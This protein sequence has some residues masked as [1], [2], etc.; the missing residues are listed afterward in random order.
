M[1]KH[2]HYLLWTGGFDSTFRLVE[3]L[4]NGH[5]VQPLYVESP[6][7]SSR[8][9][10]ENAR[11]NILKTLKNHDLKGAVLPV[12]KIDYASIPENPEITEAFKN[13]RRR[14]IIGNQYEYLARLLASRPDL[15]GTELAVEDLWSE[16]DNFSKV[17]RNLCPLKKSGDAYIINLKTS[18]KE[19]RLLFEN[20]RFGIADRTEPEMLNLLKNWGFNDIL[21][22]IWFC[23]HPKNG[24]PCGVCSPCR[25]KIKSNLGELLPASALNRYQKFRKLEQKLGHEP[26]KKFCSLLRVFF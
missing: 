4:K 3:L 1:A 23:Y 5:T 9:L 2:I 17:L 14:F 25:A 13:I 11:N 6:R 15:R 16:T 7:R 8:H 26:A 24:H 10:E 21:K 20:F 18:T 12:E 19:G 22:H